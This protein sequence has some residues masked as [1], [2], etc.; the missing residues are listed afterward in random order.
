MTASSPNPQA[1]D[2]DSASRLC[3]EVGDG[4]FDSALGELA[5]ADWDRIDEL[6]PLAR[7][8]DV[9][10]AELA[11]RAAETFVDHMPMAVNALAIAPYLYEDI[12]ED[13][14][15]HLHLVSE[16]VADL[17][18]FGENLHVACGQALWNDYTNPLFPAMRGSW[19]DPA[20]YKASVCPGCA[21]HAAEFP[22]TSEGPEVADRPATLGAE[23]GEAARE[24][25]REDV[26][27]SLRD[28]S[29]KGSAAV[30]LAAGVAYR[31][32]LSADLV[33]RA[34][35]GGDPLLKS[36]VRSYYDVAKAEFAACGYVGTVSELIT[37][38]DWTYAV[39]NTLEDLLEED[40][41]AVAASYL[42][43][44][45]RSLVGEKIRQMHLAQK[46]QR[47]QQQASAAV[48]PPNP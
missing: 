6:P 15:G 21:V 36:I 33:E 20:R 47:R 18:E 28:L 39:D 23:V 45:L 13:D 12:I 19:Q 17:D 46:P 22:E 8:R 24:R 9:T 2:E 14:A 37:A 35:A 11:R 4:K 42:Y 44:E 34:V 32:R 41:G 38:E 29:G 10:A 27:L 40:N 1:L 48:R 30:M 16:T 3:R 7:L 43:S 31:K 5:A 25:T 26:L